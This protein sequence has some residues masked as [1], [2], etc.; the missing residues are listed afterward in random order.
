MLQYVSR[1]LSDGKPVP[2]FLAVGLW[3]GSIWLRF[4]Q[5][6]RTVWL[7]SCYWIFWHSTEVMNICNHS[8]LYRSACRLYIDVRVDRFWSWSNYHPDHGISLCGGCVGII[9]FFTNTGFYVVATTQL[10]AIFRSLILKKFTI[11]GHIPV[12]SSLKCIYALRSMNTV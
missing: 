2:E 9:S 6:R 10:A 11:F 4:T 1:R 3:L 12:C 5:G 8:C 7:L